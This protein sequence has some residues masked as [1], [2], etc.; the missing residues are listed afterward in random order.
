M[1][2]LQNIFE[3][4]FNIYPELP[5]IAYY[6]I[7]TGEWFW[8]NDEAV[9]KYSNNII[10]NKLVRGNLV[11]HGKCTFAEFSNLKNFGVKKLWQE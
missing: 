9:S 4:P 3:F 5:K 10:A 1:N 8:G 6:F 7:D 2:I 11:N